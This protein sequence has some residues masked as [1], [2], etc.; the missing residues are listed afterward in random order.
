MARLRIGA[1]LSLSGRYAR[2]GRQ[3]AYGLQAWQSLDGTADLAIEDDHSDPK[4]LVT[5][6]PQQFRQA[7]GRIRAVVNHQDPSRGWRFDG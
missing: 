1:C 7:Q 6:L 5:A 2:F 3:A 4:V